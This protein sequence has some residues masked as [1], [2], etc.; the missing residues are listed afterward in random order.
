MISMPTM[1]NKQLT[2][3]PARLSDREP[4]MEWC[5]TLW[6]GETDYIGHVWEAWLHEGTL[7]VGTNPADD[8][9]PLTLL[10]LRMLAPS[11]A[12]FG[13]LRVHPGLQGQGIG[14]HLIEYALDWAREQG[15]HSLG[16]M[17]ETRNIRM[18]HLGQQFGFR[19]YGNIHWY[20]PATIQ[21]QLLDHAPRT[22]LTLIALEQ[23]QR[24]QC[25][26]QGRYIH[27]WSMLRLSAEQLAL[28]A[29]HNQVLIHP[30]GSA[31]M[32][33]DRWEAEI[34]IDYLA[35][36]PALIRQLI[37]HVLAEAP[38]EARLLLTMWENDPYTEQLP[39]LGLEPVDHRYSVF[40]RPV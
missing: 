40:E 30:H 39:V 21:P 35:G 7:L 12:W 37:A 27:D 18:H 38:A 9:L 10:R 19:C 36:D 20:Q 1:T 8:S 13:G 33:V 5:N 25:I 3:R 31:W 22:D 11:E 29:A 14:R 34:A 23:D 28:H 4:L 15:A 32:I 24:L 17:T 26:Q 16:Y 6:D 2:L